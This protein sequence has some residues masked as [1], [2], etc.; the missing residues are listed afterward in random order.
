MHQD[1]MVE[2]GLGPVDGQEA[3]AVSNS[4]QDISNFVGVE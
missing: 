1:R 2:E 3:A 4:G